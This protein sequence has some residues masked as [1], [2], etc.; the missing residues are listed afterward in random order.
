MNTGI[1]KGGGSPH[2]SKPTSNIRHEL[3]QLSERER[4][5]LLEIAR[6]RSNA[7]IGRRLHRG[8]NRQE[9]GL[10]RPAQA[11]RAQPRPGRD[12]RLR[13]RSRLTRNTSL[14]HARR[15]R[16]ANSAIDGG[17]DR[18]AG[19]AGDDNLGG[20]GIVLG[21]VAERRVPLTKPLC[22]TDPTYPGHGGASAPQ[23]VS[24]ASLRMAL[25]WSE[26]RL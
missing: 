21:E 22:S 18:P 11:W 8:G 1:P 26:R 7:E 13:N 4:D 9:P 10:K 17:G 16:V 19:P 14:T 2:G 25:T 24:P 23:S 20:V 3:A 6:G 5:V 15:P 12:L